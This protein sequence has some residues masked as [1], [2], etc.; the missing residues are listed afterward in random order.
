MSGSALGSRSSDAELALDQPPHGARR[1]R[2]QCTG[3]DDLAVA[4]VAERLLGERA[5]GR[6]GGVGEHRASRG[7][8][9]R[10]RTRPPARA[11]SVPG[12]RS[13]RHPP[14]A[15]GDAARASPPPNSSPMSSRNG[16]AHHDVAVLVGAAIAEGDALGR[17][18][19]AGVQQVALA[20]ERVGRRRQ[21]ET[22]SE[23]QL[24]AAV[25][26]EE[27]ILETVCGL[28]NSPS[29]KPVTNTRR[30]RRARIASGSAI[31]TA[32]GGGGSRARA[33]AGPR[34][35]RSARSTPARPPVE[36]RNCVECAQHS[37]GGACV[38]LLGGRQ[39]PRRARKGA[40]SSRRNDPASAADGSCARR[41]SSIASSAGR[42]AGSRPNRRRPAL[43]PAAAQLSLEPVDHVR[44]ARQA[45]DGAGM[46]SGPRPSRCGAGSSAQ[47]ANASSARPSAVCSSGTRR[48]LVPATPWR[49][50]ARSNSSPERL[51]ERQTTTISSAATPVPERREHLGGDQLGLGALASRLHQHH[52]LTRLDD[53]WIGLE[54]VPL[55]VMQRSPRGRRRSSRRAPAAASPT[56]PMRAAPRPRSRVPRAPDE[57]AHR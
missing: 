56:A 41:S 22:R 7:S 27:R 33:P 49:A 21:R 52:G 28:G 38:E 48:A 4:D 46:R 31:S 42:N 18:R 44:R 30:K 23:R 11:R 2:L 51:S 26:A 12:R 40:A 5:R 24:A 35:A 17:T 43:R 57:P 15:A 6:G 16:E 14:A 34:A 36:L 39:Q 29:Q 50:S 32:S 37:G 10:T 20:V 25:I 3:G 8:R 45:P 13:R 53:R 47:R 9:P 55:E 1:E 19:H 54:Q